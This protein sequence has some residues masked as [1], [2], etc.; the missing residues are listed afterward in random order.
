MYVARLASGGYVVKRMPNTGLAHDPACPSWALPS[1][2]SGMAGADRGIGVDPDTGATTVWLG[3]PLARR[4][5]RRSQPGGDR[6]SAHRHRCRLPLPGLL[7]YLWQEA[8]LTNWTPRM[9]GKRNW[10]VIAWHLRQAAGDKLVDGTPL[11]DRLWIP[12]PFRSSRKSEIAARRR[13]AWAPLRRSDRGQFMVLVGELKDI[14]RG[15][16]GTRLYIRHLPDAPL[17]LSPEVQAAVSTRA[18]RELTMWQAS[19]HNRL[20]VAV[21]FSV[22]YSGVAWVE[23]LTTMVTD[24]NW[25]PYRDEFDR[26]LMQTA[27]EEQ[28]RFTRVLSYDADPATPMAALVFT[29]TDPPTAALVVHPTHADHTQAGRTLRKAEIEGLTGAGLDAW[30]WPAGSPMPPLPPRAARGVSAR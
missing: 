23:D 3:F 2:R 29:D 25:L 20:L 26:L 14:H 9:A 6:W 22:D 13:A 5:D 18:R 24:V 16:V 28:R 17:H 27:V 19:E 21:L 1:A 10:P 12:E 4:T 15:G 30:T 11:A 7:G 8:G